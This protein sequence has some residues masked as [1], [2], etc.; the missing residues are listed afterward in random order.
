MFSAYMW[1]SDGHFSFYLP[2]K[3]IKSIITS[4]FLETDIKADRGKV[5]LAAEMGLETRCPAPQSPASAESPGLSPK[6][7]CAQKHRGRGLPRWQVK[8][9]YARICQQT[10]GS[11]LLSRAG[12]HSFSVMGPMCVFS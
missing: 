10:G 11:T 8:P 12:E 6:S 1:F 5:T 7:C 9:A 2:K 3:S 4:S